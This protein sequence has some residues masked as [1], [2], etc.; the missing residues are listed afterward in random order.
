MSVDYFSLKN[1][2]LPIKSL[3]LSNQKIEKLFMDSI[4]GDFKY[5]YLNNNIIGSFEENVFGNL[6]KLSEISFYKNLIR[7]LD[8]DNSFRFNMSSVKKLNFEFNKISSIKNDFFNTFQNIE[9]L[10][11]SNNNLKSIKK[12]YL[13]YLTNLKSLN[14]ANNQ[15]LIIDDKTFDFISSLIYLNLENNLI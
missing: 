7:S 1:K 2:F 14:F 12:E 11:L 4:N 10:I 5:L 3:D 8:F 13:Y 6:S 9:E 15:I